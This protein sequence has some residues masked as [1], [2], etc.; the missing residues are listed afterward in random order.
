MLEEYIGAFILFGFAVA[1]AVGMVAATTILG[2]KKNFADKME[3]FECGE[4]QLVSPHQRFSVKFYLIA[5]LFILFDVEV[6]FLFPWA[7]IYKKLGMFGL[8][9]MIVFLIILGVG[10]VYVWKKGGLDWE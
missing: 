5:V 3:P 6:V 8:I 2:P 1:I 4:S 7:I 9:E 10:L